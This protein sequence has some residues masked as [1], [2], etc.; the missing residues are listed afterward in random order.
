MTNIS[1]Q[2]SISIFSISLDNISAFDGCPY[3]RDPR[4]NITWANTARNTI[5]TQRCPGGLKTKGIP[6]LLI[7]SFTIIEILFVVILITTGNA[8]R[9]CMSDGNWADPDV[10]RC[11]SEQFRQIGVQVTLN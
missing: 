4:W 9:L 11:E 6:E 3:G 7:K 8:T 10:L 5:D 2:S 1:Y